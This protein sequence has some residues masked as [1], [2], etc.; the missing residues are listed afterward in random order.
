MSQH[1]GGGTTVTTPR[2][3]H[4]DEPLG[5]GD[6]SPRLSWRL[7]SDEPGWRQAAYEIEVTDPATATTTTT[8]RLDSPDS[9]LVPWPGEPLRSRA[10]RGVRVRVWGAGED[11]PTDWSPRLWVEAGLLRAEDWRAGF[12][13]PTELPGTDE[14]AAV[15]LRHSF[16]VGER[17]V[18]ARLYASALGMY[19]LELNGRRVGDH[20]L[21]PGWTSY[22]TRLRYQTFDVTDLVSP[23]ENVLGGW[24]AEGWYRGRLGFAGGTRGIYGDTTALLVQLELGYADGR[25]ELVGTGPAW[26]CAPSPISSTSIYDGE[27]YDARAERPGWSRPGF[28]ASE[29]SEVRVVERDPS[30]LVAP[31]GPPVRRTEELRPVAV[32]T[33]P[34][35]AT[36][37]D[38]GQNVVGR[39]RLTVRGE[40]GT[41]VRIRHAEV[42]EDG[43]LC[44]RP[45][46]SARA[47]D[48]Y[49]LDGSGPRSWE[50]R[51]TFHGFRYAEITGDADLVDVVARVYHTD[52]RATGSFHCS[53]PLVNQLHAN[54]VRSMRGNFVDIPTDCP[55]RDERL[56]W[57]GDIQVFTPT[58]AFLHDC[59]GMLSSWLRDLAAEQLPDGTV[60]FFVPVVPARRWND[61]PSPA[62]VWGDAAVLVPWE[63][64]Q[65]F[66]DVRVLRDQYDSAR[67]WVDRVA[68]DAGPDHLWDDGEQLGDW[69]DPSAPAD[70]PAGGKADPHLVATAYF[71]RSASVVSA[72]AGVLGETADEE[73]Y[74]ALASRVADAFVRRW[75]GPTG[76]VED[77]AQTSY[78]LALRFG[79]IPPGPAREGAG[80][81]LAEL[82]RDGGYRIGTG[83]AGTPVI[84]DALTESGHVDTAYA[85]LM[86]REC[87]SWLYPV[88]RGATTIWERW[89]SLLPDGTVNP[90]QMTSFN[91]YALG[92]VAD[93]LHRTV[94]GLAPAAP[95]YRRLLVRPVPGGGLTHA[96]ASHDTPYGTAS[97][98]W[99]RADG[100]LGVDLVVPTGTT[101]TVVLPG[102]APVEVSSGRH[103]WRVPFGGS[104]S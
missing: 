48:G 42:L 50:P 33:S 66:G 4:H 30:T 2:A 49:V 9:V 23:G 72:M 90:G 41:H 56:G 24:L 100:E 89:D 99:C 38:F 51:F 3:E 17:P 55:Q 47:T 6:A 68:R 52:M 14:T 95:G 73:R 82:V 62:A 63:L 96:S 61:S 20:A 83:F 28:D 18:T 78:A 37:L 84:C 58:A 97:V 59:A 65:R 91:H 103:H 13:A 94:A 87:P 69:L 40:E 54:V 32:T 57:T 12:V 25:V 46:R 88:T 67:S 29:W 26:R 16:V 21:A 101:A 86:R 104:P 98:A 31:T 102:R 19:E 70:D 77:D 81:R 43:E 79:L 85:L 80:R 60:P 74:A 44:V 1:R 22:H 39:L 5:I 7:H 76:R 27:H 10:R 34:S 35:G 92:A 75:V 8:G 11:L 64:Y 36:I 45:L 15:L 71:A 53:D 93:W